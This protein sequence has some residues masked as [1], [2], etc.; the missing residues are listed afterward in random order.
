MNPTL[1]K[2]KKVL[3][4]AYA[5]SP[6]RGSEPG[7]GWSWATQLTQRGFDVYC[8]TNV[9][10]KKEILE[11]VEKKGLPNLHFI[12]VELPY[13]LDKF[14]LDTSSKKIYF[15]YL[16][17]QKKAAKI[18]LKMHK[19]APFD[20]GHHVTFGSLQQ[21]HFLWKLPGLK[22]IFGPVGGGQKALP[23]LKEYFGEAWKTEK[24][25]NFLSNWAIRFNKNFKRSVLHSD[26]TLV[27]NTDTLNM[28]K[29]VKRCDPQKISFMPDT[30]VPAIMENIPF[31]QR[32]PGKKLKL[33]W[34]GRLLPRKGLNL[35]L[36]ALSYVPAGV[37]Y[38]LTIVGGGER[39]KNIDS[40]I[41]EFGVDASRLNILGQIPFV[42]V[43]EEYKKADVFIFCSLR[44]SFGAQFTEAMAF[45]LPVITLNIHGAVVCVPENC[46]IKINPVSKEATLQGIADAIA[47]MYYDT[48]FREQ[49]SLNT[50]RHAKNNTWTKKVDEVVSKFY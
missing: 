14:L 41:K 26:F 24:I 2:L 30:A 46:G 48:E 34:V 1:L 37:D 38:S 16:L 12:F 8:F 39:F 20:I 43:V 50:Y 22:I 18:A 47:K 13:G 21:G 35:V 44:D 29:T 49:C 3:L 45:A 36:E 28:A 23:V 4:S 7:N 6:F 27:T 33:L 10:D 15:H 25:R 5:C 42:E 32:E 17:W 11:A 9:E 31:Q 40:W 19:A